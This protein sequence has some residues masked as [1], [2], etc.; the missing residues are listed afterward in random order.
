MTQ[1]SDTVLNASKSSCFYYNFLVLPNGQILSTD[2]SK[3]A[4]VYTPA[5]PPVAKWAPVVKKVS[6]RLTR[7]DTYTVRG[8]RLN[9][10]SQGAYYGDDA[11]DA[12]NYP[13]VKVVNTASGF[14][15]YARTVNFAL[16]SVDPKAKD[17][18]AQ[19]SLPASTQP[20]PASLYVVANGIASAPVSV[21]VK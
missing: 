19:F 16:M 1:V 7:S 10:V 5:G 17:N 4:E 11:Q 14:V 21:I 3:T 9:G 15:F 12:T 8:L 20:G 2:F 18:S 6:T 13:I